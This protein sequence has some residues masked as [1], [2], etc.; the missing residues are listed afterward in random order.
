MEKVKKK[1]PCNRKVREYT[2]RQLKDLT[3]LSI[4]NVYELLKENGS[5]PVAESS[6]IIKRGRQLLKMID[7]FKFPAS[8]PIRLVDDR[9]ML[10][11]RERWAKYLQEQLKK[12]V[13]ASKPVSLVDEVNKMLKRRKSSITCTRVHLMWYLD[14][15]G[16]ENMTPESIAAAITKFGV[17][18]W[19][20]VQPLENN[21]KYTICL[22]SDIDEIDPEEF[23]RMVEFIWAIPRP[24]IQD[25]MLEKLENDIKV[26]QEFNK[27]WESS[28][29]TY[30]YKKI[31]EEYVSRLKTLPP[32]KKRVSLKKDCPQKGNDDEQLTPDAQLALVRK[33]ECP[34]CGQQLIQKISNTTGKHYLAHENGNACHYIAWGTFN[35]PSIH[36][37]Y[38]MKISRNGIVKA[39]T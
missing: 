22:S 15:F 11:F 34:L 9:H 10:Q 12:V 25:D 8:I 39:G 23:T 4:S 26:M 24:K 38:N 30:D 32:S 3:G 13:G 27:L 31:F 5:L 37:K 33:Q 6:D 1:I 29:S 18:D 7:S 35:S 21:A 2:I 16:M 28:P 17:S 36:E 20:K 19:S 14:M